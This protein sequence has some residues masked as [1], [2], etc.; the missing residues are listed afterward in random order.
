MLR[1]FCRD[2]DGGEVLPQLDPD[3]LHHLLRV[4]RVRPGESIEVL[5]GRGA[6]ALCEIGKTT[7][8]SLEIALLNRIRHEPPALR[9]HLLVAFP[10][11][12]TLPTLLQKAV[13]LG[14]AEITPLLTEHSE[15]GRDRAEQKM[16]RLDSVLVEAVKQSGN[17]WIPVLNPP[18]PL[19]EAI[20][21]GSS[22]VQRLCAALQP[23]SESLWTLMT[24]RLVP[25][26]S[27]E[28][29]VGPEG[30]FSEPEYALLRESGCFFISLGP[31]VLRVE[32]AASLVM[33]AL[34]LWSGSPP[35]HGL[36]P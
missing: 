8:K 28:V 36:K 35:A 18:T 12:K 9:R 2:W 27:M 3:E 7:G 14:V 34:G 1:A 10:K 6:V 4:R 24:D 29:Y 11:G 32:T 22:T 17:P 31:L 20:G 19:D 33:G 21:R 15:V 25:E 16:D 13:E 5:N 23:N 26:G 30:D